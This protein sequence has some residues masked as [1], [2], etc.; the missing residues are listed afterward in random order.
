MDIF[1]PLFKIIW[2]NTERMDN[3][4]IASQTAPEGVKCICDVP[5]INDL[6]KYHLLDIYYPQN[7]DKKLPLII[8]IHG[9]GWW[10]GTKEINKYYC[11]ALAQ[12]GF[13][14]ANI[15]YRLV[16][17]VRFIEQLRDVFSCLK[18]IDENME[19]YNADMDNVFI[20]GDSA[21][22]QLCC[23]TA[24]IN[25]DEKMRQEL[26]LEDNNL[27]FKA[28]AATSPVIDLISPNV[29]MNANLTS[30][31]GTNNHKK[32]PYYYLMKFS[33]IASAE[34]PPFYIVTSSG[35]FVRKQSYQLHSILD[36]LN[37]ENRFRDFDEKYEG[38]KL[39]HVFS[40]I[41]PFIPPSK[42]VINELTGFFKSHMD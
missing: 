6:N 35:D 34:L 26:F 12:Q 39:T 42:K 4:R 23:L 1:K 15:N 8:D 25:T 7:M 22:G 21:G 11:M 18:W 27:K 31:L 14:V 9:G 30:L 13:I 17:R 3:A 2:S 36:S 38:K 5:Y 24:Q 37:V 10:Y 41:N 32:S 33:N 16:D 29:M 19:K 20:T 28:A 40:V